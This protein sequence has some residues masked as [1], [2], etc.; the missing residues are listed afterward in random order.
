MSDDAPRFV[1]VALQQKP[2]YWIHSGAIRDLV[3]ML[4]SYAD[5]EMLP[6][7]YTYQANKHLFVLGDFKARDHYAWKAII[8]VS[9][10]L[11]DYLRDHGYHRERMR[12]FEARVKAEHYE[13]PIKRRKTRRMR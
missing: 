13:L 9:L 2:L 11:E 12:F 4:R 5:E 1:S 7:H 8:E 10:Q 3:Y 6:F